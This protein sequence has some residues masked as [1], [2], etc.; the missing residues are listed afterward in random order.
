MSRGEPLPDYVIAE[1]RCQNAAEEE[2]SMHAGQR[3]EENDGEGG[4]IEKKEGER[5]TKRGQSGSQ[6]KLRSRAERSEL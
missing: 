4:K 1:R 6:Q 3:R 5:K 2:K